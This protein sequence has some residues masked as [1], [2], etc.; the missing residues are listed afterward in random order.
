MKKVGLFLILSCHAFMYEGLLLN[1]LDS[2][3]ASH[4]LEITT[5]LICLLRNKVG[6][7][8]IALFDSEV[9]GLD[10]TELTP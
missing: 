10:R 2:R 7:R 6:T 8:T 9:S 3:H 4:M 1:R 5:T